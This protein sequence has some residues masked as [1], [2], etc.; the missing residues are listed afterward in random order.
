MIRCSL[1][2]HDDTREKKNETAT[3]REREREREREKRERERITVTK[4]YSTTMHQVLFYTSSV[5]QSAQWFSKWW[6]CFADEGDGLNLYM[7]VCMHA[8][9][10]CTVLHR[11][12]LLHR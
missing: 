5:F 1:S 11:M 12:L 10:Y 8:Q 7:C 6:S 2:I 4:C 9:Y 3:E